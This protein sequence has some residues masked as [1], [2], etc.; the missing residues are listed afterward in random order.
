M[1]NT[2]PYNPL[3]S[4]YKEISEADS[5]YG[6]KKIRKVESDLHKKRQVKNLKKAWDEHMLEAEEYDD[7][8]EH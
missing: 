1:K 5:K 8:Y 7:F 2:K 3:D 4:L 6:G